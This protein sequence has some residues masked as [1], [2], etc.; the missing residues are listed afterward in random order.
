MIYD[1]KE[2][3]T[4]KEFKDLMDKLSIKNE[5]EE[6]CFYE[7]TYSE[8]EVSIEVQ[9]AGEIENFDFI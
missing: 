7:F 8:Q 3:L 2:K 4:D 5:E 9:D 6:E 1:I